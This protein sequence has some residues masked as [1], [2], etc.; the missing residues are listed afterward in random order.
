MCQVNACLCEKLQLHKYQSRGF[1][2]SWTDAASDVLLQ[3]WFHSILDAKN[4]V[5]MY[6]QISI[7]RKAFFTSIKT[8]EKRKRFITEVF[9]K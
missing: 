2:P 7:D 8:H 1:F 3:I 9:N 4:C 6:N 5:N